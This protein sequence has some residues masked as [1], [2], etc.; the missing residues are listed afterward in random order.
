MFRSHQE[1]LFER[2][3]AMI[4]YA[5]TAAVRQAQQIASRDRALMY[6]LAFGGLF[7]APA[8]IL[9]RAFDRLPERPKAGHRRTGPRRGFVTPLVR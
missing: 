7:S 9:G 6:R 3:I 1:H 8:N 5:T 4:E 2:P